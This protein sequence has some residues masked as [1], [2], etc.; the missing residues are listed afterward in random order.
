MQAVIERLTERVS[1]L[2]Q[3]YIRQSLSDN[4]VDI[5][6]VLVVLYPLSCTIVF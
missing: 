4:Q 1:H 2:E 6:I 3:L 5:I